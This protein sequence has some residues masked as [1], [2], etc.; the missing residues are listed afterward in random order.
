MT[1]A[2]LPMYWRDENAALWQNF[3]SVVQT[4]AQEDGLILPDLLPP[5]ALPENWIS[6][7]CAP[8]LALSMTCGLPLRTVLKH[9]V[10]YVGTLDFQLTSRRGHYHSQVIAS[11]AAPPKAPRL[12]YNGADSQS[13]WAVS[14]RAAPFDRPPDFSDHLETG[15][16]AASLAAVAEDRA[17]IAYLDA[18]SWRLLARFDPN[19]ARVR[20]LGQTGVSPGLPLITAKGNDPAPL[21]AALHK[22][23]EAFHCD[24]PLA[25]GGPM[26]FHVLDDS[27]YHAQPVPAPPPT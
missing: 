26:S 10:T 27:L 12:A 1:L 21:R 18:V 14:Q 8:E 13:G 24:D 9:R 7:W 22:A 2:S 19:A 16:H 5:S 6:H 11:R 25:M 4:K 15:S 23:T 20:I 17:D 3:W